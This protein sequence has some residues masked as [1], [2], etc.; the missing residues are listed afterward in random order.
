MSKSEESNSPKKAVWPSIQLIKS[1]EK[2]KNTEL[3]VKKAKKS[4]ESEY[5]DLDPFSIT[6]KCIPVEV[7][8][9]SFRTF[10]SSFGTIGKMTLLSNKHLVFVC[11]ETIEQAKRAEHACRCMQVHLKGKIKK[12]LMLLIHVENNHY[13]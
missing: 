3:E 6:V 4:L 11:Y 2:V 5:T 7:G 8:K 1:K 9:E 13:A 10:F 12:Q